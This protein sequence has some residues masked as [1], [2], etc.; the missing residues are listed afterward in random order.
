MYD[1]ISPFISAY[2]KNY[3]TQHVMIR[4]LEEWRE[5]VDK[6]YI[7]GGVLM[8]LPKAFDCIPHGLLLAKLA[9]Y[10]VDENLVCYIYSYLIHRK[11][12][13]RINN[14]NSDFLNVVSSVPQGSIVGSILFN[15][16]FNDFFHFIETANAHNF[17]DDNTLS[18]FANHI[19]NLIHLLE[20]E[21][22]MA[23]KWFK[24]NKMIV[25]PGKFQAIILDKKKNNHT[26]EKI[27]IGKNVVK[28]KS[29]VKLLGVQIDSELNF[30]LD[31]ANICRSAANQLNAL[32]RLKNLLGFQEKKILINSY[33]YSNFN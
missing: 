33:F 2:R 26:Q 19:K 14:I 31:I 32:I 6:N 10:G 22:S 9:A 24:D 20:S 11:Q 25:N 12:Y 23:I 4:L 7:V 18:D 15:C 27:K 28:V 3:N 29:S 5:N 30:T 13:V 1:N 16:F 17:A 21:C 8:D